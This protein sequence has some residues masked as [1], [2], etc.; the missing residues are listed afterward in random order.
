MKMICLYGLVFVAGIHSAAVSL[1]TDEIP[2]NSTSVNMNEISAKNVDVFRQ[3]LNQET[4]IR[5]TMV[6]N[7]HSLMKDM[8]TL[9]QNLAEAENKISSIHSST[10]REISELNKEVERLKIENDPLKN[11]SNV[12][13]NEIMRLKEN[14]ENVTHNL[15]DVKVEV[16]YLSITV[17]GIDTQI[18]EIDDEVEELKNWTRKNELEIMEKLLNYTGAISELETRHLKY[19]DDLNNTTIF[20]KADINQYESAQLKMSAA[21]SSLKF[22]RLNQTLSKC[23]VSTKIGFTAS[24]SSSS[25]SWTGNTLVFPQV[26]TN[27]GNGYNPSDGVFTAPM[28][29]VYVFFVNVQSYHQE[30]IYVDIVLNEATKVRTMAYDYGDNDYYEAGPNL[31]VL[32]LQTGGKVWVKRYS[33]KGYYYEGPITTFSGFII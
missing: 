30:T 4:L 5:M 16:R 18:K 33:G 9:Q 10:D 26:I 21:V 20:L 11:S 32:S 6:K 19:I 3:L 2:H 28:A 27:V 22:F 25:S 7:V 31:A 15:A 8:V 13:E 1:L 14:L 17:F 24:V 23:E 12:H 29:G